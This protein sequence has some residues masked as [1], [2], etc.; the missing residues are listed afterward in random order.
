MSAPHGYFTQRN[1]K[2][3]GTRKIGK[4]MN[5]AV[6]REMAVFG[7]R[8]CQCRMSSGWTMPELAEAAGITLWS[9]RYLERGL[10]IEVAPYVL[11][12]SALGLPVWLFHAPPE[13]WAKFWVKA[14]QLMRDQRGRAKLTAGG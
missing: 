14:R 8:V 5:L 13:K 7:R 11:A 12:A 1:R 2:D 3:P 10:I 4:T 6:H 9:V